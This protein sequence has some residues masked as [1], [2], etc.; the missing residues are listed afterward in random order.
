MGA[1][2]AR[3]DGFEIVRGNASGTSLSSDGGGMFNQLISNL[4]ISRCI[5]RDNRSSHFG[6]AIRND[7]VKGLPISGCVFK[8]WLI[9]IWPAGTQTPSEDLSLSPGSPCINAGTPDN[10]PSD[11]FAGNPRPREKHLERLHCI[12]Y[13]FPKRGLIG[14]YQ[15]SDFSCSSGS[16]LVPGRLFQI[17][18]A[19]PAKYRRRH[20]TG[21]RAGSRRRGECRW[22]GGPGLE[23]PGYRH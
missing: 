5:F 17:G 8:N 19:G 11:D 7:R 16:A 10:S 1:S 9:A 3:L 12:S 4:T 6:G 13:T 2:N 14:Y 21:W 20:R 18:G 15:D 22:R 23:R